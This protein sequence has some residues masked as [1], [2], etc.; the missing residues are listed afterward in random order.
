MNVMLCD[1]RHHTQ[2]PPLLR[3]VETSPEQ[4]CIETRSHDPQRLKESMPIL[5]QFINVLNN[6]H[7]KR[8]NTHKPQKV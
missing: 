3:G 7:R 6:A 8:N 4:L 2:T 1:L 5:T